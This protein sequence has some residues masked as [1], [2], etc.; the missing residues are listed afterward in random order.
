MQSEFKS[1]AKKYWLLLSFLIITPLALVCFIVCHFHIQKVSDWISLLGTII[2]YMGTVTISVV[3]LFQA[4]QSNTISKRAFELS[5][6][7]Y[8]TAFQLEGVEY[9]CVQLNRSLDTSPWGEE[10]EAYLSF[11]QQNI[12]S[13]SY[14][15]Y[16]IGVKNFGIYPITYIS[17]SGEGYNEEEDDYKTLE[18]DINTIIDPGKS[19][20]FVIYNFAKH[21]ICNT[22]IRYQITCKNIYKYSTTVELKIKH[23]KD[24]NNRILAGYSYEILDC[25]KR[26]I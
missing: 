10:V 25:D 14:N 17:I 22:E 21:D 12:P 3:A 20:Y 23:V 18:H 2:T 11:V 26:D 13:G 5:S 19:F 8:T 1:F 16:K 6:R 9:R 4:E 15:S 24:A 7:E